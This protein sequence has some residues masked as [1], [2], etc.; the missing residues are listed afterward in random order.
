MRF[1]VEVTFE[2]DNENPKTEIGYFDFGGNP[3]FKDSGYE[4]KLK[5]IRS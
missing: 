1:G 4:G 5:V 3:N 2:P